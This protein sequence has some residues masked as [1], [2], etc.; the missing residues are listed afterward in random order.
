M[1]VHV[2][3]F[4]AAR[5]PAVTQAFRLQV[6]ILAILAGAALLSACTW[7][8]PDAGM[9]VVTTI[10]QQE[11]NKDAAAIRS[12]EEAEAAAARVRR[13]L[14]RPL[15]ADAPVQIA[16]LHNRGLQAAYHELVH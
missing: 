14:G 2:R 12:P 6:G 16:L 5:G 7:F 13:L 1:S 9:G 11:L 15:T 8:S 4:A 10:A 3:T